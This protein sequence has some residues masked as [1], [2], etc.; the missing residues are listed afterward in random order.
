MTHYSHTLCPITAILYDPLNLTDSRTLCPL[1]LR[2]SHTLC[3]IKPY[4]QPYS[5]PH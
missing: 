5:M 2:D 1:N 4:R 3:P